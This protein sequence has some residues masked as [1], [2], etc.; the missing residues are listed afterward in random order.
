MKMIRTMVETRQPALPYESMTELF[1]IVEAA[2]L[3]Q[4]RGSEPVY[5]KELRE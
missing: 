1:E 3:S 2:R 4:A 5:L